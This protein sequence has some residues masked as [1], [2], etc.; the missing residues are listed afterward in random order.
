MA[1]IMSARI[2]RHRKHLRWTIAGLLV[3]I[4]VVPAAVL[5]LL[6]FDTTAVGHRVAGWVSSR[7]GREVAID[8]AVELQL[9]RTLRLRLQ[10]LRL[11]NV[12]WGSRPDMLSTGQVLVEIDAWSLVDRP[13]VIR[14][15]EVATLDLSLERTPAGD[16]NWEFGA[17]DS[18]FTWP[19]QLAL[20]LEQ[21]S[22]PG[23]HIR[24]TGPRLTTPLD[25]RFVRLAQERG[26]DGMLVLSGRG[27]ANETGFEMQA[28][29]GPLEGLIAGRDFELAL[30]TQLGELMVT[31][32]AAIDDLAHP[33]DSR[34]LLTLRGPDAGYLAS[35]FGVRDLGSGPL[36]L[37][38]SVVPLAAGRGLGAT[39][40]GDIGA[41]R[42]KGS[43]RLD[44]PLTM[45]DL[46]FKLEASGPDASFLGGLAGVNR[47]PPAPFDLQVAVE[48]QGER[49]RI[50][51]GLLKLPDSRLELKGEFERIG[52]MEG[53]ELDFRIEGSDVARF[54][55]LLR[56]PG[57]AEGPFQLAGRLHQ[58][59]AGADRL[60]IDSI[61]ALGRFRLSGDLARH[62]D[63]QGTRIRFEAAGPSLARI[64]RAA[65][66]A[67]LPDARFS[68]AGEFELQAASLA[69]RGSTLEVAGNELAWSGKVGKVPLGRD[70]DLRFHLKGRN[71][72]DLDA[73]AGTRD[74]PA[75]PYE[76]Q[77]R[78]RRLPAASRLDEVRGRLAGAS[79]TLRG[80]V[81]DHFAQGTDIVVSIEGP[82]LD[83]F[84]GLLPAYP[85]PSG[86]F[87][88][89]GGLLFTGK[90][91]ELRNLQFAAGGASGRVNVSLALPLE[92]VEGRFDLRAQ[93][94]DL[95]RLLPQAGAAGR[96]GGD[97]ELELRGVAHEGSWDI[98][99]ARLVSAAGSITASGGLVRDADLLRAALRLEARA[100]SL[101]D[102]G[103]V[104][105]VTLPP[106]PLE[107]SALLSG[108]PAAFRMDQL[109][110]RMGA[111]D[112]TGSVR[113]DRRER[114]IIDLSFE[115][116][117]LDLGPFLQGRR[118]G[119]SPG[120]A[121]PATR[122]IP[123]APLPLGMLDAFDGSVDVRAGRVLLAG[124]DL[125]DLRLRAR[126][127]RGNLALDA[128][129]LR[130]VS[131]AGISV[132]G[133][134]LREPRGRAWRVDAI[135][136]RMPLG[137]SVETPEQRARRPRA[138]F[139]LRFTARGDSL[140][141]VAHTMN[142]RLQLIAGSGELRSGG[143]GKL[144]SNLRREL[145]TLVQP[146][147]RNLPTRRIKCM[148]I[149]ATATEGKVRTAPVLAVQLD[150][151]SVISH[152][153]IDLDTE[154]IE[155]YLK[156]TPDERLDISFGEI[157]N[158]YI[159]IGGTFMQP[160]LAVDPKGVVF[161]S[162]A[163]VATGGLSL[164]AKGTWERL[165]RE[166][167]PC[168]A[169]LAAADR[170]A[171]ETGSPANAIQ[172]LRRG[173]WRR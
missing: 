168:A 22:L 55:D 110:G 118:A 61:T 139:D 132:S 142:G 35:R 85:W 37:D 20:I 15:V 103:Q 71:L 92:T 158:P 150:D 78:L 1:M 98:A 124:T 126:L 89:N 152:G 114:P 76:V 56:L 164:V 70:T 143:T 87:R 29:A 80:R 115:A 3:L 86:P 111:T 156:T 148:S 113:L 43:G 131:D 53:S 106:Q 133:T 141:E 128:L 117:L 47:L 27:S 155:F 34:L 40:S 16:N 5:A 24:F 21:V 154:K 66:F 81:A 170:L 121:R 160:V 59:P 60:E 99:S 11:A 96:R 130:M 153:T 88:L 104:F 18:G 58:S 151:A 65:D 134:L 45:Q 90:R 51:D 147:R 123:D 8:G 146:Q 105:G 120:Q 122:L 172:R 38:A 36:R 157:V 127:D 83:A 79:F 169:A 62:P 137:F 165:F 159:K 144:F 7:I 64:G 28:S 166:K 102:V 10:G 39:L 17:E 97:F 77:G 42:V 44:E 9:G 140:A 41:F 19:G 73:L 69:F 109:S 33:A 145:V 82:E 57:L 135:G 84:P 162:A 14:R 13:I 68:A 107:F 112:F 129:D 173:P 54:R 93:G 171:A 52:R 25:L 12:P 108:T 50:R 48:R 63:Y 4:V 125:K 138:D 75:G 26:A 31:A 91:L 101:A 100:A 136:T 23:A 161:S 163:A 119:A 30:D 116:K 149:V 74:L 6:L 32:R 72:R 2:D 95:S 167:D 94:P 67:G 46:A 49:L